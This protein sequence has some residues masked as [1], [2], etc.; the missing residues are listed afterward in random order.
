MIN[1]IAPTSTSLFTYHKG[2]FTAERSTLEAHGWRPGQI[3]A[4]AADLGFTLVSAA[5]GNA[6]PVALVRSQ[7]DADGDMQ[8]EDFAPV[9]PEHKHL[10]TG[11]RIFND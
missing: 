11:V 7:H 9:K 8:W 5:T 3:R 10:F 4:D 2:L 1:H 6:V